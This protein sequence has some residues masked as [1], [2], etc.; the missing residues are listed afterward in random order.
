MENDKQVSR[1]LAACL[2][3]KALSSD[4]SG[5]AAFLVDVAAL[6]ARAAALHAAFAPT[7]ASSLDDGPGNF[8]HCFAVKANPLF[9]VLAQLRDAG[10]GAE[11]ASITEV[12]LALRAGVR[13]E[14]VVFD[15]PV[16]TVEDLRECLRAGVTLNLDSLEE[17]DRVAAIVSD[18]TSADGRARDTNCSPSPSD[19]DARPHIAAAGAARALGSLVGVRVNPAV[20]G[21][22]DER[23]SSISTATSTSKFGVCLATCKD[24]LLE[25]FRRYPWLSGLHC[26]IGSQGVALSQLVA[27]ARVTVDLANAVNA[28]VGERRVSRIDIGGGLS[29]EYR[30]EGDDAGGGGGGAGT[31]RAAPQRAASFAE[32]ADAL[33]RDVPE[34]FSGELAV[35]TEFGRSLVNPCGVLAS[36]VELAKV[37]GGRRLL[38][39]HIGTNVLP[40]A[41]MLP[42]T[43]RHHVS[44]HS[45]T[46]GSLKVVAPE[47]LQVTDVVGPL[48]FSGDMLASE[49]MLPP[50]TGGDIVVVHD[51]GGYSMGSAL[52]LPVRPPHCAAAPH[53]HAV[54][55]V[56]QCTASTTR[57]WRRRCTRTSRTATPRTARSRWSS[58]PRAQRR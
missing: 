54:G 25:A 10:C 33:R 57:C 12:R 47:D 23:F 45:G 4:V 7:A 24:E 30:H 41:T 1:V 34:L 53:A 6:R 42:A 48:C 9:A 56:V 55:A 15:C 38:M 2:S 8:L 43:W 44:V 5:A 28:H 22:I 50:T 11:C 20:G 29:V 21:S 49:R 16:K 32:Y 18:N 17:V 14:R 26:H 52:Q 46:D 31:G 35:T 36:R 40:R 27:G 19:G 39:T 58:P 3:Q 51:C 13:P 37:S